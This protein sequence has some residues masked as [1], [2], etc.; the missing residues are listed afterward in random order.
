MGDTATENTVMAAVRTPGKTIMHFASSNYMTQD[1]C[2]FLIQAGAK[3]E[4]IGTPTITIEGV[5]KL[6]PVKDYPIMP[7][8]IESMAFISIAITTGSNLKITKCPADFLRLELEKL[9][10]MGQGH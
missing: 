7:D 2:Y 10:L 9:R 4:G 6:K 5:K 8:P 3:I 1:L